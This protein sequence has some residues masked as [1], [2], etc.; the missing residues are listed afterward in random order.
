MSD[1]ELIKPHQNGQK[2]DGYVNSY[3]RKYIP[4]ADK[5]E[6][7]KINKIKIQKALNE[8]SKDNLID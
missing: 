1:K 5:A 3:I 8:F 7:E 4:S 2:K 6:K